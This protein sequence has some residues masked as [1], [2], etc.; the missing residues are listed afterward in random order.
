M[1]LASANFAIETLQNGIF[2]AGTTSKANVGQFMADLVT[3]EGVWSTWKGKYPQILNEV[4]SV[5]SS[6]GK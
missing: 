1:G 6:T 3:D 2:N 5:E 4:S